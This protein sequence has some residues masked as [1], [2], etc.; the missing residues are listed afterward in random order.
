MLLYAQSWGQCDANDRGRGEGPVDIIKAKNFVEYDRQVLR[1]VSVALMVLV[2]GA[3]NAYA[4]EEPSSQVDQSGAPNRRTDESSNK[5]VGFTNDW[6]IN[7]LIENFVANAE[8]ERNNEGPPHL[9]N[10]KELLLQGEVQSRAEDRTK[11]EDC[12][13]VINLEI[14]IDAI[15]EKSRR[16]AK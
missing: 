3:T 1:Q 10:E 5:S 9:D 16:A 12:A 11:I 4:T 14:A 8:D 2:M 13:V 15:M 7:S 6:L